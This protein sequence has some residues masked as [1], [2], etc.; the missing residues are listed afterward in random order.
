MM[1]THDPPEPRTP[2]DVP[3]GPARMLRVS[4]APHCVRAGCLARF[5]FAVSYTKPAAAPRSSW[6]SACSMPGHGNGG[7]LVMQRRHAWSVK[8]PHVH[9][10]RGLAAVCVPSR[11]GS[12]T[13]VLGLARTCSSTQIIHMIG[14][15]FAHRCTITFRVLSL[16]STFPDTIRGHGTPR[17]VSS[18]QYHSTAS[19]VGSR[20]VAGGT[21]ILRKYT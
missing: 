5:F 2:H 21:I 14:M 8:G 19:G 6:S 11:Y 12:V 20:F 18:A 16:L 4:S 3:A 13:V 7:V 10:N 9:N 1:A 17:I 15:G